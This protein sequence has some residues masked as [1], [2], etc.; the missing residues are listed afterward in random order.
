MAYIAKPKQ[1]KL[2]NVNISNTH[3]IVVAVCFVMLRSSVSDVYQ[4]RKPNT[5]ISEITIGIAKTSSNMIN[6]SSCLDIYCSFACKF[7]SG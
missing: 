7:C 3:M 2:I 4:A 5:T 1:D 6:A